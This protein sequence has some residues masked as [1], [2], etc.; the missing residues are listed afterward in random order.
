MIRD[1]EHC[2]SER[3]NQ[4]LRLQE[5]MD[6]WVAEIGSSRYTFCGAIRVVSCFLGAQL[7]YHLPPPEVFANAFYLQCN[8]SESTHLSSYALFQF[9]L[10]VFSEDY[11]FHFIPHSLKSY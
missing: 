2:C 1:F 7:H 3:E 8:C 6:K 11:S 10:Q 4:K 9:L 5:A